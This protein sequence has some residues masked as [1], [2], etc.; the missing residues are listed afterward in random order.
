M[1]GDEATRDSSGLSGRRRLG[2]LDGD[3]SIFTR[4]VSRTDS[5]GAERFLRL[6]GA[7]GPTCRF[8][9]FDCK[10]PVPGIDSS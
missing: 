10:S 1:S 3:R 9:F 6:R 8:P 2:V 4:A 5:N 7:M